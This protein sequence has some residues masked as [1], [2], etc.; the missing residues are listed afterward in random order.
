MTDFVFAIDEKTCIECGRCR[1]YCPIPGAIVI[2]SNYQHTIVAD[3]CTDCGICEAFCPIPNVIFRV[4]KNAVSPEQIK[5]PTSGEFLMALRRVVWRSK[6]N[7]HDNPVMKPIAA[8]ARE[9]LKAFLQSYRQGKRKIT[10]VQAAD[11][12]SPIL[13]RRQRLA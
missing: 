5:P 1:R 12:S 2:N 11:D 10:K 3:L 4:E 8:E 13:R 6:W 7:Y 9:Q